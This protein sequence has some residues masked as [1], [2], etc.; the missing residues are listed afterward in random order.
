[1]AEEHDGWP[2][3][4]TWLVY[5][6]LFRDAETNWSQ[7]NADVAREYA[8]NYVRQTA[9]DEDLEK[10]FAQFVVESSLDYFDNVNWRVIAKVCNYRD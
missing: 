6:T 10:F 1:M 3:R 2:N 5:H 9:E 7:W 4:A 8:E